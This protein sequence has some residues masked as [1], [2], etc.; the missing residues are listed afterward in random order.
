MSP[1]TGSPSSFGSGIHELIA[2]QAGSGIDETAP[3]MVTLADGTMIVVAQHSDPAGDSTISGGDDQGSGIVLRGLRLERKIEGDAGVGNRLVGDDLRDW[4]VGKDRADV[5]N[6][7]GGLDKMEGHDGNDVY[8]L[9][10]PDDIVTELLNEGTDTARLGFRGNYT[11]A[12]YV[13][14]AV[15][16]S[17]ALALNITGNASA[18]TLVGNAAANVLR[19][20]LLNDVLIGNAGNDTLDGGANVDTLIGGLGRDMMTGG[21]QRDVF[22]FNAVNETGKTATT[23]DVITDFQHN[24]DDIDVSTID[25]NGPLA[26]NGKFAFLAA[27][28]AAFTGAKGQLHWFQQDLAGTANDKTIVE[29]DI[30]GDKHADFAIELKG[31]IALGAA[32]FL[33]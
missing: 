17:A 3:K 29:G 23:R 27:K 7:R 12:G 33:L 19:G 2:F 8:Y 28:G 6:G 5:L 9:D 32:D 14:N 13:E 26:G 31:L 21:T 18:N 15:A 20:L 4:L 24:L 16:D 30:N 11:L 25:A 22:D 1:Q 10:R